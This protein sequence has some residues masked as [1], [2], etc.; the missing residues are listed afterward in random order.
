MD[1][2]MPELDGYEATRDL[3]VIEGDSRHTW[4]VAMTANSLEGDREK[5]LKAGMDDY[6]SKPVK[7]EVLQGALN[8][9]TGL[10]AVE[11]ENREVGAGGVIDLN[12]LAGFREMEVEGETSIL[13]KL[14]DVFV[15]NTP[16]VIEDAR[17]A[18][19]IGMSPQLERA[20]HTLKGSCSNFGAERMRGACE[21]LE[22]VARSGNLEEADGLID[23]MESEFELV[24]L[25]LERERP[26]CAAV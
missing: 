9:F 1:C 20:A 21:R 11:Q 5:C 19:R 13:G 26:A 12:I 7:P 2:Q 24:R 18:L 16:R 23:S 22:A 4:I 17:G 3:R 10:R 25:A 15:E 6:V 14:I 8:R